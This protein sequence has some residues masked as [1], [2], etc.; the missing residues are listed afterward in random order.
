MRMEVVTHDRMISLG[1]L[2]K[3]LF[4]KHVLAMDEDGK[5]FDIL[6]TV[7][8]DTL[9]KIKSMPLE[10]GFDQ[11]IKD[12]AIDAF[13]RMK[14]GD[15]FLC[16]DAWVTDYTSEEAKAYWEMQRLCNEGYTLQE[17]AKMAKEWSIKEQEK[18][19]E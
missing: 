16:L 13:S 18:K 1:V 5:S 19:Q 6:Q 10:G 4:A 8:E 3:N 7:K 9:D 15:K 12:G 17:S 11:R 14:V 2:A